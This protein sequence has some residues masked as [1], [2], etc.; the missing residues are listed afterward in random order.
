MP[1]DLRW[2][3][4]LFGN[5]LLL[6]L[7]AMVNDALAPLSIYLYIN[8]LIV[9]VP[10]IYLSLS[11]GLLCVLITGIYSDAILLLPFGTSPVIFA[12]V[13]TAYYWFRQ[14][15]KTH[16]SPGHNLLYAV[17]GN[18]FLLAITSITLNEGSLSHFS[19]W[20]SILL[21]FLFSQIV[22]SLI[23]PW[24]I[25]LQGSLVELASPK[26]TKYDANGQS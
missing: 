21:N 16:Y 7:V 18:A 25:S 2:I 26:T 3:I 6:F 1:F 14:E 17:S 15:F 9:L 4:I 5:C 22:L 19:Y 13:F 20:S 12:V 10:L 23:T 8:G 11:K 24:F